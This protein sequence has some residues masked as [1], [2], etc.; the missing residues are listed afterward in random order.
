VKYL[1][2]I[3]N[4]SLIVAIL[5]LNSLA[6]S[7]HTS[8]MP[9]M[10]HDINSGMKHSTSD[11]ASCATLCRTAVLN[12]DELVD[13]DY[14]EE[15]DEPA[16]PFYLLTNV[17]QFNNDSVSQ[18]IYAESVKPPPKIPIYILYAVYRV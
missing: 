8:A 10:S 9:A 16:I 1:I 5:L 12:K 15:N 6:F 13:S 11:S 3:K 14:D 2:A 4:V 7:T 17:G 18:K